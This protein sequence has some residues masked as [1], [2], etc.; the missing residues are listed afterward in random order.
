MNYWLIKS[1]PDE[2]SIDNLKAV[3]K[4]PWTGVRNYQARNHM[5]D[6]MK[7]GDVALF[8]HSSTTPPGIIGL[9]EVASAPYAD[10]TQ[11]DSTSDY[12]D[13]K[14]S[15]STPRWIV[16]DIAYK[17]T[18]KRLIPLEELRQDPALQNMLVIKQGM[19]L[20]VQPV[21]KADFEHICTLAKP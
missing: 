17:E 11:F 15:L 16:V 21:S 5:R 4:E 8:Y 18:F 13:P 20:S 7:L 6:G 2:F 12:F 1:E 9:A 10:P 14:S 19:R 3:G